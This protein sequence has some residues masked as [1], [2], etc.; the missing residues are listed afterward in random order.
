[1]STGLDNEKMGEDN[2]KALELDNRIF[3]RDSAAK[4]I[5][6]G[7][8]VAIRNLFSIIIYVEIGRYSSCCP[9]PTGGGNNNQK[10]NND[11]NNYNNHNNYYNNHYNN[12]NDDGEADSRSLFHAL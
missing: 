2:E 12:N 1:M 11:D 9:F 4:D 3:F 10:Y 7:E 6:L 8:N 5:L